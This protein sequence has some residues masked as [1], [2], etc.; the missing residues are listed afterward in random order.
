MRTALIM[1]GMPKCSGRRPESKVL[2]IWRRHT[3]CPKPTKTV[4]AP[5]T[6][7]FLLIIKITL[8]PLITLDNYKKT[9]TKLFKFQS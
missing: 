6:F 5:S 8:L 9:K 2:A 1:E 3:C 7:F 4:H